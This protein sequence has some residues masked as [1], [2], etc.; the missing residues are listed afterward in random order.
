MR[1][2]LTFLMHIYI[3]SG[4][5]YRFGNLVILAS[6]AGS[7]D[8]MAMAMD[9]ALQPRRIYVL[10]RVSYFAGMFKVDSV[11]GVPYQSVSDINFSIDQ[12]PIPL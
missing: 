10:I 11:G 6:Y 3:F 5:N 12:R 7:E 8:H 4:P 9:L 2:F 1:V